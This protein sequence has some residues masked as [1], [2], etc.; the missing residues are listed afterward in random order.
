MIIYP[1]WDTVVQ[2]YSY[3]LYNHNKPMHIFTGKTFLCLS[4][5]SF[6]VEGCERHRVMFAR[7]MEDV[8][9]IP[10]REMFAGVVDIKNAWTWACPKKVF[11]L[12][13]MGQRLSCCDSV[14]FNSSRPSAAYMRQWIGSALI[15]IMACCLFGAKFLSTP[16]LINSQLDP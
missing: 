12:V 7:R 14:T 1:C 6:F 3:M 16:T 10:K 5:R 13:C 2:V 8:Q 4:Y 11:S 9:W 15:Q